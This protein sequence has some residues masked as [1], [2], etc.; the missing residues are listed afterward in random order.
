MKKPKPITS[1]S[2][3]TLSVEP[4]KPVATVEADDQFTGAYPRYSGA[5]SAITDGPPEDINEMPASL[6]SDSDVTVY[7]GSSLT[8]PLRPK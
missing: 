2:A 3:G 6:D 1:S 4:G 5:I 7:D 8:K